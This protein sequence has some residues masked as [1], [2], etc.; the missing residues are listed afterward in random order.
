MYRIERTG[1]PWVGAHGVTF[2][3]RVDLCRVMTTRQHRQLRIV[4]T[5]LHALSH[6]HAHGWQHKHIHFAALAQPPFTPSL[7]T[8][9]SAPTLL[10]P[11]HDTTHPNTPHTATHHTHDTTHTHTARHSHHTTHNT[12]LLHPP[13]TSSLPA[14][15]MSFC[16]TW[17]PYFDFASG[18]MF[19]RISPVSLALSASEPSLRHHWITREALW[20]LARPITLPHTWC[21]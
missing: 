15:L 3:L 17:R 11:T 6:M 8:T 9:M 10:P 4:F 16:T 2:L 19:D 7:D 18:T 12:T 13:G 5:S 20:W 14:T 1:H 21:G